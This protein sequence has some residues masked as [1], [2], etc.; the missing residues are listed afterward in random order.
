[1]AE[2]N[3]L[4]ND[5]ALLQRIGAF[6]TR[7]MRTQA[8]LGRNLRT[9]RSLPRLSTSYQRARQGF[10][11]NPRVQTDGQFF[12]PGSSVSNLTLSGRFL[13]SLRYVPTLT[14]RT[15]GEVMIAATGRRREGLTNAQVINFLIDRNPDYDIFGIDEEGVRQVR[16]IVTR[17]L[18][19]RLRRSRAN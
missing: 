10:R 4:I 1:M 14:G 11:S 19:R 2:F 16:A 6:I 7:R 12:R 17:E 18:R 3:R 9:G 8:R 5:Q 13:R 15:R